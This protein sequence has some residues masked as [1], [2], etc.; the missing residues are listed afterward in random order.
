LRIRSN[1]TQTAPPIVIVGNTTATLAGN[2]KS[3]SAADTLTIGAVGP[4]VF[5]VS[6]SY[7]ERAIVPEPATLALLGTGLFGLGI[8]LRRKTEP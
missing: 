6:N 3:I 4:N 2:T 7:T 1:F 8:V 5:A